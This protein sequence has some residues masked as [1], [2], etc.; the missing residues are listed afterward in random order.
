MYE[1]KSC[2]LCKEA[3]DPRE[4]WVVIKINWFL[5]RKTIK[6]VVYSQLKCLAKDIQSNNF[7][8][9]HPLFEISINAKTKWKGEFETSLVINYNQP[10]H[11]DNQNIREMSVEELREINLFNQK[12]EIIFFLGFV[13]MKNFKDWFRYIM[14]F[15]M[16]I[17]NKMLKLKEDK[18]DMNIK[19]QKLN[20]YFDFVNIFANIYG[21]KTIKYSYKIIERAKD[22]EFQRCYTNILLNHFNYNSLAFDMIYQQITNEVSLKYKNIVVP[23]LEA[24]NNKRIKP[25]RI[26]AYEMEI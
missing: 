10:I 16:P 7:K 23:Y 13:K 21:L 4:A 17:M 24:R 12:I 3:I 25:S 14:Y 15:I 20:K 22:K 2:I 26:R 1:E 11:L 6:E 9:S 19:L 5:P 18:V 8:M